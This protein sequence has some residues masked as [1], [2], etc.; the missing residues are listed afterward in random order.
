MVWEVGL[1]HGFLEA[2]FEVRHALDVLCGGDLTRGHYRLDLLQ[3]LPL[4]TAV[5]REVE[6][7][8]EHAVGRLSNKQ[9]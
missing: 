5:S 7:S 3:K 1:P 6:N 4:G 9:K 2:G 8:P